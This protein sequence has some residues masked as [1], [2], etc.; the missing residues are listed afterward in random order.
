MCIE[1]TV[2]R[3]GKPGRPEEKLH[4]AFWGRQRGRR[5]RPSQKAFL[6]LHRPLLFSE[7]SL[8]I[9]SSGR[10]AEQDP[11][12]FGEDFF[13]YPVMEIGLEIGFGSGTHLV[14]KARLH[15]EIG[16]IGCDPHIPS[17][18]KTLRAVREAGLKNVRLFEAEAGAFLRRCP[19]Q[20]LARIF[21]LYPDPWPK[22]RHWKRRFVCP[23]HLDLLARVLRPGGQIFFASDSMDYVEWSLACF[24]AHPSFEEVSTQ[25]RHLPFPEW[26]G[27][28]YEEK[29]RREGRSSCYLRFI[30][31][32]LE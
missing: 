7:A 13:A 14:H 20:S 19:S 12:T 26:P 10:E 30:K 6:E 18:L 27:T 22:R 24:Q 25:E 31:I 1:V 3:L 11:F 21:L 2:C 28:R 32:T 17:L 23:A 15:P 9:T 16:F 8:G 4:K 5:L 29:A